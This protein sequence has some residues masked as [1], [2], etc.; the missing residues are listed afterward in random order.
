MDWILTNKEGL[1]N[2]LW[3]L[4]LLASAVAA[5]TPTK[6]DDGVVDRIKNLL[7]KFLGKDK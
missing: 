1:L 4:V 7:G 2:A 5:L 6:E 3:A